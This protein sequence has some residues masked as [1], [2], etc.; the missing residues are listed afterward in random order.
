MRP[1][2]L[3]LRVVE[4]LVWIFW[5]WWSCWSWTC[6]YGWGTREAVLIRSRWPRF[7]CAGWRNRIASYRC[8][9][10]RAAT[11]V[12]E[13]CSLAAIAVAEICRFWGAMPHSGSIPTANN[14]KDEH[15][16]CQG[17]QKRRYRASRT[18][19]ASL[20]DTSGSQVHRPAPGLP[21]PKDFQSWGLQNGARSRRVL[22]RNRRGGRAGTASA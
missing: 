5:W 17:C 10:S 12:A 13:I 14:G 18:A 20:L 16:G 3:G 9:V 7:R 21:S 2:V 11:A 22:A 15:H 19:C 8:T 4:L 6:G 1:L